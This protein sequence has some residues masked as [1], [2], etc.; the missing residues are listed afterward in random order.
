MALQIGQQ[1]PEFKLYD[2]EKKEVSLSDFK[3]KPVALLFFPFAFTNVCTAELCSVRDDISLYN[4]LDAVMLGISVDSLHTLK[5]YKEDQ[6]LNFTLLSDFNKN[7]SAD[8]DCL[9]EVFG[10]NMKGV[11]KRAIFVIDKDGII[12]YTEVHENAGE[13][14]DLDAMKA[15]LKSL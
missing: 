11:S 12:R 13:F 2:T 14:P 5:K 9:Y 15:V 8:Y 3:G 10:Q 7:V 4:D 6:N 1:A